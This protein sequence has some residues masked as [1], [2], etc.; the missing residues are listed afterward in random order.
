MIPSDL[1]DSMESTMA[2]T[3][4]TRKR[5]SRE[6]LRYASDL[7]DAEWALIEPMMPGRARTGRPRTTALRA[8]M[9]AVLYLAATGCQWRQL[10]RDF[11]LYSAGQGY[12]Y[13]RS[14]SGLLASINH[15]LVMAARRRR[16]GSPVTAGAERVNSISPVPGRS[17]AVSGDWL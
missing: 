14:S 2:W 6:G 8:V 3:K 13:A 7:T 17:G 12:F 10:P 4:A 5:H 1:R 9:E 16:W 11:P 15:K